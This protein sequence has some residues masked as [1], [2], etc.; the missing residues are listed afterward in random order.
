MIQ[1][2]K[3]LPEDLQFIKNIKIENIKELF[4]VRY[5]QPFKETRL[6][7][8][9]K[10]KK[11]VSAL[12]MSREE[13]FDQYGIDE[14]LLFVIYKELER[15]AFKM[16]IEVTYEDIT[17]FSEDEFYD[18][19]YSDDPDNESHAETARSD[20]KVLCLEQDLKN[21]NGIQGR[22]YDLL[23]LA[24][25]HMIQWSSDDDRLLLTKEQSW[26]VGYRNHD[27]S[28]DKVVDLVSLYEFE[29][30][31]QGVEALRQELDDI[32]IPAEQKEAIIQFFTDYAYCD[33]DYI[34]QH[35]RGNHESFQKFW[36]FGQEIPPRQSLPKVRT[37]IQRHSV[38]LG[39]I[40]DKKNSYEK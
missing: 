6:Q 22:M 34:I 28:P 25:G 23:H 24:F 10:E 3:E 16:G 26:S 31:M 5:A 29:A 27:R 35:Y 19:D 20:G 4:K 9:F 39:L 1:K 38:E 7:K 40:Q 11:L 2:Q 33:R 17:G 30:G 32:D 14:R 8:E 37:F 12:Q 21:S 15:R 13:T 18:N 36:F